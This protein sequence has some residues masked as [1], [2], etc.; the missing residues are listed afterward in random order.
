MITDFKDRQYKLICAN[1]SFTHMECVKTGASVKVAT[2]WFTA[3]GFKS[4]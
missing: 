4:N 1:S 2:Q 3:C